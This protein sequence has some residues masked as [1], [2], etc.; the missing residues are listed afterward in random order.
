MER[1][2]SYNDV[3]IKPQFSTIQSRGDVSL[4]STIGYIGIDTPIDLQIPVISA[5]MDTITGA[6]MVIAMHQLGGF[7]ILHR[8]MSID[9]MLGEIDKI[10]NAGLTS[11]DYGVS[12]GVG[13]EG[14]KRWEA[15]CK[16]SV[17]KGAPFVVCID[18]AHGHSIHMKEILEYIN[19]DNFRKDYCI[20]AGNVATFKGTYDLLDWGAN[21]IKI[22][23]GPGSLCLTRIN[24]GVGVPQLSAIQVARNALVEHRSKNKHHSGAIIADGGIK[25]GGDAVKALAAG[26]DAIMIGGMLAGCDETPGE[27]VFVSINKVKQPHNSTQVVTIDNKPVSI[28]YKKYRGMAS[29]DVQA[30][31]KHINYE[32][33][34]IEGESTLVECKGP[35]ANVIKPLCNNIRSGMSYSNAR[36]IKE[37]QHNCIHRFIVVTPLGYGENGAHGK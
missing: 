23:I 35:V 24:T 12:I 20:I 7:G 2:Y 32:D 18:V 29:F 14:K 1:R 26:A 17:N 22:G 9:N 37:L 4:A 21:I 6:D 31:W 16:L 25:N 11:R 3:L 15:I 13:E 10:R 27:P 34:H 36:N 30:D 19:K 28:E 33:A 5:N 8:F